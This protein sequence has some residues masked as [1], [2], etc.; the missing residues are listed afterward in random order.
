MEIPVVQPA[1][2]SEEYKIKM[3][4]ALASLKEEGVTTGIFGDIDFEEH[5]IWVER[6]CR[7]VGLTAYLPL[8]GESQ[9]QL[10]R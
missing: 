10:V 9:D 8:G 4:K 5:R 7:E 3:K 1:T 6:V 2:S